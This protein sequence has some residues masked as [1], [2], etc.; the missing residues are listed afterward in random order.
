[1]EILFA[2]GN[3]SKFRE[4]S[5]L[6]SQANVTLVQFP[7]AHHE[8]RSD[9]LE[10]IAREAAQAAFRQCGRPVFVEDS[11]FFIDALGAFPGTYSAWVYSKLGNQGIL[12]LMEDKQDRAASFRACI[13]FHDGSDIHTFHGI[14]P[15]WVAE[16]EQGSGGF[17]YDPI[18]VPEGHS[19]TFAQSIELKNK[20]S[21]RYK[22]LQD[23]LKF[24]SF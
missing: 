18:F 9:S 13:A 2:T 10:E 7:F 8:I 11:G 21:H 17:G 16:S 19:T 22:A 23:F 5:L 4:A 3:S 12:R 1:M 6:L 20:L 15:G 24:L 14:C